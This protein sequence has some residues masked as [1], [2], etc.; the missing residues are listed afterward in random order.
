[1][2][3]TELT[4]APERTDHAVPAT[5][6][7]S[8]AAREAMRS[9]ELALTVPDPAVVEKVRAAL[10]FPRGWQPDAYLGE[11]ATYLTVWSQMELNALFERVGGAVTARQVE[12][13]LHDGDSTWTATEI[14]LTVQVDGV[15]GVEV[16][17][18]IEDDPEH[19]Y[20]TDVPVVAAAR[21]GGAEAACRRLSATA[22]TAAD[23]DRLLCL[24]D[25]M[26]MCRCQLAAAGRL[27]LIGAA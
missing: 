11:T 17:T 10:G 12:R 2:A 24:Q 19:G 25:E 1:M 18:D 26:A 4:G 7:L 13:S 6:P 21:H 5:A 23:F 20:R 3:T 27:D 9:L 15:G 8:R 14:T 22:E 16:V